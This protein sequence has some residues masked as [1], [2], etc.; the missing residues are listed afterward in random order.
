MQ[1]DY[2]FLALNI[3]S[4]ATLVCLVMIFKKP[5]NPEIT[6]IKKMLLEFDKTQKMDIEQNNQL[7]Q[8]LDT[9][10]NILNR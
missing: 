1:L 4:F 3:L 2:P 6:N 8:K 5:E 7:N 10:L 9:I